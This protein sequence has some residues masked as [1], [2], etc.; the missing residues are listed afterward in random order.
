MLGAHVEPDRGDGGCLS[1]RSLDQ[2]WQLVARLWPGEKGRILREIGT[3][4]QRLR[5]DLVEGGG[6][7]IGVD[8]PGFSSN[9]DEALFEIAAAG[10]G[11]P[12]WDSISG[13]PSTFPPSAHTHPLS[14]LSVSGATAGQVPAWSGTEWEPVTPATGAAPA[15][16][17][18]QLQYR[19]DAT[20]FGGASLWRVNA[21]T[22]AQHNGA[23]AQVWQL[24]RTRTDGAN[25]EWLEANS[26]NPSGFT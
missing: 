10:G 11:A 17:D 24:F 22:I 6:S 21:N 20:T 8:V 3:Q 19:V 1:M 16:S 9:L 25:G 23:N 5:Y 15:G 4:A 26:A 14:D 7:F 12:T 13:K 2:I 18:L